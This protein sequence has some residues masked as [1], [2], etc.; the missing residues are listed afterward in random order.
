M[1]LLRTYS[2]Q[3]SGKKIQL[4]DKISQKNAPLED[5][6]EQSSQMTKEKENSFEENIISVLGVEM[7]DY[8]RE[9]KQICCEN[10]TF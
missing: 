2:S 4:T 5:I 6:L 9:D 1:D 8:S 3:S 7:E 10:L